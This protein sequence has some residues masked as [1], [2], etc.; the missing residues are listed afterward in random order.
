MATMDLG[1]L[2]EMRPNGRQVAAMAQYCAAFARINH[3]HELNMYTEK[4]WRSLKEA[5]EAVPG[6]R[7]HL[8]C[9]D[10]NAVGS[11][12]EWFLMLASCCGKWE[13]YIAALG[14]DHAERIAYMQGYCDKSVVVTGLRLTID[15]E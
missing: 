12:E 4:S 9:M 14:D 3:G 10:C 8:R 2:A 7:P 13:R 1:T 11:L 6:A 15:W 5:A